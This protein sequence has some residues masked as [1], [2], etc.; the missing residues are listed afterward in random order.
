MASIELS[1][2]NSGGLV[3]LRVDANVLRLHR[4]RSVPLARA[5]APARSLQIGQTLENKAEQP[6]FLP[7]RTEPRTRLT[8]PV[9][10][11]YAPLLER[12]RPLT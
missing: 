8:T 2:D 12:E 5:V 11:S 9:T 10:G 3:Q 7:N 1:R 4:L 6:A